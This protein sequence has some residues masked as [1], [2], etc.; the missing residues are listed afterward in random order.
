MAVNQML[1]GLGLLLLLF[2]LLL[3]LLLAISFRL[4]RLGGLTL[5]R[6]TAR[7][8]QSRAAMIK[9]ALMSSEAFAYPGSL[10]TLAI[11]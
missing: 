4:R 8:E 5:C 6:Q 11:D 9:T 1:Q 7:S 3:F 10:R 2:F